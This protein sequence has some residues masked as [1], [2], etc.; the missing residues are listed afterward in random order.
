M[1]A[2][3]GWEQMTFLYLEKENA[4]N[5]FQVMGRFEDRGWGVAGQTLGYK[6]PESHMIAHQ[7]IQI[8]STPLG[9]DGTI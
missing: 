4:L 6:Q 5:E 9:S 1:F 2:L 7:A 3:P 8:C